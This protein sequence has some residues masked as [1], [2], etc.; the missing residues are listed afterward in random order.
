MDIGS[1]TNAAYHASAV[2]RGLLLTVL[3]AGVVAPAAHAA[4]RRVEVL[5]ELDAP[6]LAR[7][8]VASRALTSAA[9]EQ[10][11]DVRS[12]L[13][14]GYTAGLAEEQARVEA[15]IERLPGATVRRRYRIVLNAFAVVL[16]EARLAALRRMDG[17]RRVVPVVRYRSGLDR[18]P[19]Q[20]GAPSL[21]GPEPSRGGNGIKIGILDDGVDQTHP[22]FAP[23]G[24][25]YPSGFPKGQTAFTTPKVIVARAF[26]PRRPLWRNAAK[27]FDAENSEHG[28]HVAGIAAGNRGVYPGAARGTISGI[29]PGAWIGNYKI[30]T[31]PTPGLGLNGNSPE[32]AAGIEAAVADGM[33][34][35]NLSIGEPETE[36]TRDLVTAAL[37]AAAD[38]GV[39]PVISAG[40]DYDDFGDGSVG[41]PGTTAKAI[42][43]GSVTTAESGRADVVSGF[44]SAGPTPMSLRL[45]PD[46]AAPGSNIL[47]SVPA[48]EGTWTRLS[49]TSM[50]APHV[51]GGVALLRARNPSWTV[52]QL[53]SA[54]VLTGRPATWSGAEAL[55]TRVG[56]GRID[57]ARAAA[58][59]VFA[60]PSAVSLGLLR[61]GASAQAPVQLTDAGGGAGT[62]SVTLT[63]GADAVRVPATVNVPGALAVNATVPVAAADGQRTGWIVLSR[64]G[65]SRRIPFW[66]GVTVPT[67]PAPSATLTRPGIYR[68][69]TAGRPGRASSYRYPVG[70]GDT[71]A[72]PEQVFRV[73]IT[74]RVANFGVAI[75][76]RA[77]GVTVQARI[78]RAGDESAQLGYTPLPLVLNPYLP[79]FREPSS[80]SGANV[81]APG[82][83]DVVFDSAAATGAGAFSFRFWLDD[84]APPRVRLLAKN[85]RANGTLV[86]AVTD[87]GSGVDPSTLHAS[88]DGGERTVRLV[89]G[90]LRLPVGGLRPGRH[91]VR[92]QASDFQET[93]N[94][95]N[96]TAILPNTSRFSATFTVRAR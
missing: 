25:A 14:R 55:P 86:L 53:R 39:V 30:L 69:S 28:T 29:A 48:S 52:Q 12:P 92:I 64:G 76:S 1:L 36:P 65:E 5:V 45:K 70:G 80:A 83:Y 62:W 95:E 81:P 58:P 88:I 47:S 15:A 42:T 41:S 8:V 22:F 34:V 31:I 94:D 32:I 43:A 16:P 11:L 93:K 82:M 33:D 7:A 63:S 60:S 19:A 73:R 78:V 59:L 4:D 18:S 49:G 79:E 6:P 85:V 71:L 89:R 57:L 66:L 56:G 13:A 21:W 37:D 91:T 17:V 96:V 72:G 51:S 77:R 75:V 46:V 35:L 54:L 20:I 26:P 87:A 50:A 61:P 2:I 74:R 9:K 68:G 3:L 90:L 23:A 40:N 84:S 38:A 10:Q 44:S 24:F 27:A 67:L